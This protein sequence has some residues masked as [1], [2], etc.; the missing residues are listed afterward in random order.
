[1]AYEVDKEA[2][3]SR[4]ATISLALAIVALACGLRFYRLNYQSL[5]NDEITT[6][7]VAHYPFLTIV[8]SIA[9]ADSSPPGC[10]S[11]YR[12]VSRLT[13]DYTPRFF[14]AIL[15]ILGV[16]MIMLV[17]NKLWGRSAMIFAGLWLAFN[18]VSIYVSQEMRYG[19]FLALT[20]LAI[21]L[22]V[23]ELSEKPSWLLVLA[24]AIFLS[25]SIYT[26]YYSFLLAAL[27]I[28]FLAGS[29]ILSVQRLY[30]NVPK[31]AILSE[32]SYFAKS[33]RI[34][35]FASTLSSAAVLTQKKNIK[36]ALYGL[37]GAALGLATFV[38][39]LKTFAFQLIKG[40]PF[41]EPLGT[42]EFLARSLVT[43]NI[44][45]S[46]N[47][48]PVLAGLFNKFYFNT[49][50]HLAILLV[51]SL[52]ALLPAIY[53]VIIKVRA[54][55]ILTTLGLGTILL[56]TILT[57]KFP[58]FEPKYLA[59]F[60]PFFGLLWASGVSNMKPHFQ[61]FFAALC[62]C[63]GLLSISDYYFDPRY[64]QQN[65]RD[66]AKELVSSMGENEVLAF[67]HLHESMFLTHYAGLSIPKLFF[68]VPKEGSFMGGTPQEK[69]N[70]IKNELKILKKYDGVWLLVYHPYVFDP[71]ELISNGLK[72]D[73]FYEVSQNCRMKGL[74]RFCLAHFVNGLDRAIPYFK[75]EI[76]FSN[77]NFLLA[78]IAE[79]ID[80]PE[81][82][83]AWMEKEGKVLLPQGEGA[84]CLKFFANCD[85]ISCPF[86]MSLYSDQAK[87]AEV[88]V[89]K[90][91]IYELCGQHR[92][93][94]NPVLVRIISS[95]VFDPSSIY[96]GP[97]RELSVTISRIGWGK[98][99]KGRLNGAK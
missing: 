79:G 70:K 31:F 26:H 62:V 61:A 90:S 93:A 18:P 73:N 30:K 75:P 29:L 58:A 53:A 11:M 24:L 85:F 32:A 7:Y 87:I 1:L 13:G 54:R 80:K 57:R 36:A 95:K 21:L 23:I 97:K 64:E 49:P 3:L 48:L 50:L 60:V 34:R 39:F 14:S 43:I 19:T 6:S 68:I 82:G 84:I 76:D 44:S 17:A 37:I 20:F 52:I 25:L 12:F 16:I 10:L 8:T 83:W 33:P 66:A 92:A 59:P 99:S 77:D 15:G 47:D 51:I 89:K 67:Y 71:N 40:S 5:W 94:S 81:N 45:H 38:L 4:V 65:W 98:S 91:D 56:L 41:R 88:E 72:E 55:W 63:I 86:Y 42:P 69:E 22:I 46:A 74:R 27:L 78:Q 9:R 2:R 28:L 35:W 96:G